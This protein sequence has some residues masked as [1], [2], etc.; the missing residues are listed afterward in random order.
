[1]TESFENKLKMLFLY[2]KRPYLWIVTL[3]V[4]VYFRSLFFDFTYLDD[5]VLILDNLFFIKD[6]GN[7]LRLFTMEVFHVLH[8]SAAYYRPMLTLSFMIDAQFSG[9][10]P[11]FYHFTN[12]A[13]HI[14]SSCFLYIFLQKFKVKQ[15]L[16]LLFSLI[17]VVHP[18]ISQAVSWVP[19][20]NDSL[21]ALFV[22][23]TFIFLI[24]YLETKSQKSLY[25]YWTFFALS[26]FTKESALLIPILTFIYLVL[27]EGKKLN[28][29]KYLMLIPG[30]VV[31]LMIW[32]FLRKTALVNPVSYPIDSMIKTIITSWA[33]IPLYIGKVLVPY[34]LSVLP[35]IQDSKVYVG[36]FA[37]LLITS[38]VL[39]SKKRRLNYI[40]FGSVWFF[41]FLL[42]SFVRPS[43][44]YVPDFI[45]HRMYVPL[46]GLFMIIL[47]I[48]WVKDLDIYKRKVFYIVTSVVITFSLI[49]LVHTGVFSGKMAFWL[50]A[51][52]YSPQHP[53]AHKNLGA[54]YYL[55][56]NIEMAEKHF[57][58]SLELNPTEP[59]IH[60]NL[61]LIFLSRDDFANAD[62][63]FAE[64][65]KLYP[66]YDNAFFNWGLSY[67]RRGKK[68]EA[69]DM[70]NKAL[71]VNPDHVGAYMNMAVYYQEKGDME[72]AQAYY[73]EAVKRG[74][75]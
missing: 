33:A 52:R 7:I 75:K 55:D 20:R 28:T 56:G 45:E 37:L 24:N 12:I 74:A 40:L 30:L 38:L 49:T 71:Q 44:E 17:F 69:A 73:N 25:F 4:L 36:I 13:I 43:T 60:N 2:N 31:I 26:L 47:E 29:K 61:G 11:F 72:K 34:N 32:Y 42:P 6:L 14:A 18:L 64:E 22:L 23:P 63:E 51:A 53:L 62:R 1:M 15:E 50:N 39:L 41:G 66:A 8:A 54:M 70:W 58:R 9:A 19:G 27:F 35:T 3:G 5:N 46:I 57:K 21:L 59:M 68:D 48:D 10:N 67:F 16:A 65:L